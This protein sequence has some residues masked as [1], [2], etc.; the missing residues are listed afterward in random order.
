MKQLITLIIKSEFRDHNAKNIMMAQDGTL[1]IIDTGD[2]SFWPQW[3]GHV[4]APMNDKELFLSIFY[5]IDKRGGFLKKSFLTEGA[6]EYV[7]E[8]LA[9]LVHKQGDKDWFYEQVNDHIEFV[10]TL[11]K[12]QWD[13]SEA[14]KRYG[15]IQK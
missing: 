1:A 7:V 14:F 4:R 11:K 3:G 2:E 6:Y 9:S 8:V 15:L 5:L 13:Y 10:S 12:W